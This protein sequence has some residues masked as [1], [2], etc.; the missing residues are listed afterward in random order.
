MAA[1]SHSLQ[2]KN[3]KDARIYAHGKVN[4]LT[5][6]MTCSSVARAKNDTQRFMVYGKDL[7]QS[8]LILNLGFSFIYLS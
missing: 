7:T 1:A 2:P 5:S 6:D 4:S 8:A 3:K